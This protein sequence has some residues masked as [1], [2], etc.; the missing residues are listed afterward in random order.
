MSS[1]SVPP[2]WVVEPQNSFVVQDGRIVMD[3]SATGD[4]QPNITWKKAAGMTL[5]EKSILHSQDQWWSRTLDSV[6]VLMQWFCNISLSDPGPSNYQPINLN[7]SEYVTQLDNGS[8]LIEHAQTTEEG[9]FLCHAEN[10]VGGGLSKVIHLTVHGVSQWQGNLTS[11]DIL[12]YWVVFATRWNK[13]RNRNFW[14][15]IVV[16]AHFEDA[17]HQPNSTVRR[18]TNAVLEC[19]AYGD[20]PIS[21]SWSFNAENLNW[22]DN[23]RF[24]SSLCCQRIKSYGTAEVSPWLT[25]HYWHATSFLWSFQIARVLLHSGWRTR[26][27]TDH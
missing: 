22:R 27:Q 19:V 3:C 10:G 2:R 24:L 1:I 5:K 15:V 26:V 20:S 4:P 12:L 25:L 18:G 21:I 23:P 13:M 11:L 17:R 16:P 9:H 7:Q 6:R 14:I 8:L